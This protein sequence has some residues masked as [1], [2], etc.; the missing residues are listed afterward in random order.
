MPA[1]AAGSARGLVP[2]RADPLS[3]RP[4]VRGSLRAVA[5]A[6]LLRVGHAR[7]VG[8]EPQFAIGLL[9]VMARRYSDCRG[10]RPSTPERI[11]KLMKLTL[12]AVAGGLPANQLIKK[13]R[14][15]TDGAADSTHGEAG[16][17]TGAVAR[18]RPVPASAPAAVVRPRHRRR[19]RAPTCW[20]SAR[21]HRRA[22]APVPSRST[23]ANA[24]SPPGPTIRWW[25]AAAGRW[26]RCGSNSRDGELATSTGL[27]DFSRGA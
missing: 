16:T 5:T 17:G 20:R 10:E 12:A 4:R 25:A 24:C 8:L 13:A 22:P 23:R 21:R 26:I 27:S 9:H 11:M 14:T 6:V 18:R 3:L 19:P 2:V 15:S 1:A 7:H